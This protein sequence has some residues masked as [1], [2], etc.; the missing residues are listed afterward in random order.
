MP[1]PGTLSPNFIVYNND[2]DKDTL[3]RQIEAIR[4]TYDAKRV[5]QTFLEFHPQ[6]YRGD[7]A[8]LKKFVE[9]LRTGDIHSAKHQDI[10]GRAGSSS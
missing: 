4:A 7:P 2:N 8:E 1:G 5:V 3:V 6:Y 10:A 9:M